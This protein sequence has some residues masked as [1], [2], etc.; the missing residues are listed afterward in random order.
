[1]AIDIRFV[2]MGVGSSLAFMSGTLFLGFRAFLLGFRAGL[3]GFRSS[4]FGVPSFFLGGFFIRR[5]VTAPR[6]TDLSFHH[7]L[8]LE[9]FL[10]RGLGC[11]RLPG[12]DEFGNVS[13]QGLCFLLKLFL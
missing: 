10:F 7:S 6:L 11:F 2:T 4:A 13:L 1:V 9:Q 3:L 8:K 12:L 5:F